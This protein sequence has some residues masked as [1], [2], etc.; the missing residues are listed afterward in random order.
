MD[1][2]ILRPTAFYDNFT[3]DFFGRAMASWCQNELSGK[4]LQMIAASDIGKFGAKAFLYPEQYKG[5]AISLAG[6]ELSFEEIAATFKEVTGDTFP[7]TWRF[8]ASIMSW[9]IKEIGY[10][11][12][13]F[14]NTG[15]QADIEA[16]R[17]E[18]P[19]L[20]TWKTWLETESKFNK[21]KN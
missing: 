3:P 12:R 13:F 16:L 19:E 20:K 9:M 11:F 8:I 7:T 2:T 6:D 18:L 5:R 1:W 17:K 14:R 21:K 15:Y 4:K 10:M